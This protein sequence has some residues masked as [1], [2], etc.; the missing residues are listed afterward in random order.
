MIF[1][2]ESAELSADPIK[3]TTST[4]ENAIAP[5]EPTLSKESVPPA[6]P[7]KPTTSTAKLATPLLAQVSTRSSQKQPTPASV[8]LSTS[9]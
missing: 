7:M 2:K 8:N 4:Q 1:T 5:R 9:K 6:N 3:S